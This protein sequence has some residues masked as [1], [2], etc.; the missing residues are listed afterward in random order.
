MKSTIPRFMKM[1]QFFQK[2]NKWENYG[3]F[4]SQL[5]KWLHNVKRVCRVYRKALW[6]VCCLEYILQGLLLLQRTFSAHIKDV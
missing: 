5:L 4:K 6:R 3:Q 2:V 1:V